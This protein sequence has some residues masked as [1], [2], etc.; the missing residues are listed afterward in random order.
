MS[1]CDP[2]AEP[3][4]CFSS[5]NVKCFDRA[6]V[7][8]GAIRS[9]YEKARGMTGMILIPSL[10]KMVDST[11]GLGRLAKG[12]YGVINRKKRSEIRVI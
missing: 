7:D 1:G 9:H 2:V 12:K 4:A 11:T 10:L 5:C 6:E 3:L 8:T